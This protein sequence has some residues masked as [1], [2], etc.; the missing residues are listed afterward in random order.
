MPTRYTAKPK[1]RFGVTPLT[2]GYDGKSSPSDITIPPVGLEDCDRALFTLFDKEM[3]LQVNARDGLRK[4]PIIMAAGEKWA[5]QKRQRALRD[6][7]N[8]LILPLITIVR[9]GMAQD[10]AEDITGRGINQQTGELIIKRRLDTSDRS[11]QSLINRLFIRHQQNVAVSIGNNDVGQ[12]STSRPVG[13]LA[14]DPIVSLGGVM[15]PDVLDNVW[16]F[17]YVPSPQFY[18]ATYTVTIW[19]EYNTQM[20]EILEQVVSSQLQQANSWRIDTPAGYWFVARVEGNVYDADDNTDDYSEGERVLK[21]KF[22]IKV[23]AYVLGS[24]APGVPVAIR[25]FVSAPKVSFELNVEGEQPETVTEPFLGADD[26]TL[27]G[28]TQTSR[29]RDQ[30]DTGGTR[31]Y[32]SV[33]MEAADGSPDDP[34]LSRLP[35]GTLP[36][37]YEKVIG[38]DRNGKKVTRLVRVISKNAFTGEVVLAPDASLGGLE[39]ISEDD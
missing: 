37:Q 10:P 21:H 13:E 34:A 29:R 12:L 8:S 5:L 18:T 31:L 19:S 32:P 24:S 2:T 38:R 20:K 28:A 26:P 1:D 22:T 3:N 15:V 36:V 17:L 39:L 9:T 33:G 23:P 30:R 25:R 7:N 4:V 11:Y 16:E 35:R 14:T 27:P 6:R